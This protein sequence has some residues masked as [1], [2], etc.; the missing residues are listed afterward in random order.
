VP[1]IYQNSLGMMPTVLNTDL[2]LSLSNAT[3]LVYQT[4][5]KWPRTILVYKKTTYCTNWC[6]VPTGVPNVKCTKV[7]QLY[8]NSLGMMPSVLTLIKSSVCQTQRTDC[9]KRAKNDQEWSQYAKYKY[10]QN[11]YSATYKLSRSA[12]KCQNARWNR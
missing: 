5:R 3:G 11:L 7:H 1:Q 6:S 4:Y 8:Q 9:N 12:T 10:K 2:I